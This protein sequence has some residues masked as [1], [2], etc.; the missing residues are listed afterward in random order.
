MNNGRCCL[1]WIK[2]IRTAAVCKITEDM[3]NETVQ[4]ASHNLIFIGWEFGSDAGGG[5][6]YAKQ[7]YD[8][9]MQISIGERQGIMIVEF[10]RC[11]SCRC[12]SASTDW[13]GFSRLQMNLGLEYYSKELIEE[14]LCNA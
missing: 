5:R 9:V 12:F 10:R 4:Q 7:S 14:V 8:I 1:L 11:L 6:S 3:R 13:H 2:D